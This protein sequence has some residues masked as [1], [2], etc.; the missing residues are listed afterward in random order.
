MFGSAKC[1][2]DLSPRDESNSHRHDCIN[3]S[4][5]KLSKRVSPNKC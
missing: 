3:Y 4:V 1:K 2:L 5:P